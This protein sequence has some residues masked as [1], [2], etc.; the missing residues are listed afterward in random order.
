MFVFCI[1][2]QMSPIQEKYEW[3]N[4]LKNCIDFIL[5]CII[6]DR[7]YDKKKQQSDK[8]TRVSW[9]F[10]TQYYDTLYV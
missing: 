4:F 1:A 3:M 9:H 7:K 8:L 5:F 10:N 2:S 6:E